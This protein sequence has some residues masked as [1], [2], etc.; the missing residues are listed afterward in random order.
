MYRKSFVWLICATLLGYQA[1]WAQAPLTDGVITLSAAIKNALAYSPQLKSAG[2]TVLASKGERLQAGLRPNPEIGVE[3]ENL[4]GRGPYKGVDSAEITFGVSQQLEFGG[5]RPARRAVADQGYEISSLDY[6]AAQLDLIRDVTIAYMDAVA[7]Q[8]EVKLA[9]EQKKLAGEVLES[10][11]KRVS[12]A[13]EPLIQNSKAEVALAT[14]EIAFS[15]ASRELEIAKRNLASFWG[16]E[17]GQY[18]LDASDFLAIQPPVP[19][20]DIA[21]RLTATPEIARLE[22]GIARARANLDLERANA[23][24]N[25]TVSVGV[26]DFRETRDQAFMIGVS[27]PI[28]VWNQNQGNIAKALHEASKSEHDRQ[29]MMRDLVNALTRA[30]QEMQMAY[31]EAES[32]KTNI[33]PSAEK[34]FSLSRLGYQA[35]KFPYLE[36]LDAQRTLFEARSQ[37]NAALKNYHTRRA[38][39]ERLTAAHTPEAGEKG[40]SDAE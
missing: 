3:A 5:K 26:R 38:E 18:S 20:M 13:A 29:A 39:V 31:G 34:A 10:V 4:A 33:L 30:T 23:I 40:A 22:A 11:S 37:H 8:E 9:G 21:A 17:D 19:P 35:G 27:L 16:Q 24:P 7:A 1:S 14:S 25:P 15:R 12:A 2:S 6:K 32:L 28:P 36:V